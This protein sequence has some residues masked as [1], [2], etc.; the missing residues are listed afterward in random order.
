M[1]IMFVTMSIVM[2]TCLLGLFP[3]S[4][5]ADTLVGIPKLE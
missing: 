3:A 4:V 1:R 2:W 5:M